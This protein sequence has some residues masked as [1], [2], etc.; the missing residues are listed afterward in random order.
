MFFIDINLFVLGQS[1]DEYQ[2]YIEA[3]RNE[4]P[5]K[6]KF[7]YNMQRKQ[8]I[9]ELLK[10]NPMYL[11]AIFNEKYSQKA[12]ENLSNELKTTSLF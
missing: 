9:K 1:D 11:T 4:E 8:K 3:L 10:R 5:K 6:A 2:K 12:H 7:F